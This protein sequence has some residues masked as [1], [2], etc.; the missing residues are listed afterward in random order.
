MKRENCNFII[1]HFNIVKYFVDIVKCLTKSEINE[2]YYL[3]Y[4]YT[5]NKPLPA[6]KAHRILELFVDK[7]K[8][9]DKEEIETLFYLFYM[10]VE[11]G[12]NKE[13]ARTEL[14]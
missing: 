5:R 11:F 9:L 3:L 4:T 7:I 2:I 12:E 8:P 10:Y 13:D 6:L 14:E 1:E